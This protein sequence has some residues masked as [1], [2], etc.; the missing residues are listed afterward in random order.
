ML[1]LLSFNTQ[2]VRQNENIRNDKQ[3]Y[4]KRWQTK[5]STGL[6]GTG[7]RLFEI[8]LWVLVEPMS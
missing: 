3:Q 8:L 1:G 6:S 2:A 5:Q 4:Q 7:H